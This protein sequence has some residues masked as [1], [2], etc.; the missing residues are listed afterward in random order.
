MFSLGK[1]AA[2]KLVSPWYRVGTNLVAAGHHQFGTYLQRIRHQAGINFLATGTHLLSSL[3]QLDTNLVPAS[4]K[5]V[6]ALFH[7][8]TQLETV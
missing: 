3:H 4:N 7:V 5:L 1:K 8:G 6:P 2:T